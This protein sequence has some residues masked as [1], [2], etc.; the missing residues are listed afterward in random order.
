MPI[1]SALLSCWRRKATWFA[2]V[3][4]LLTAATGWW[5]MP[6]APRCS[7]PVQIVD[8]TVLSPDFHYAAVYYSDLHRGQDDLAA[9]WTIWDLTSGRSQFSFPVS[10]EKAIHWNGSYDLE[11]SPDN[12]LVVEFDDGKARFRKVPSGDHWHSDTATIFADRANVSITSQLA[13]AADGRLFV[14]V[15][16]VANKS[17]IRDLLSGKEV[18]T[19]P[20]WQ[21]VFF[22]GGCLRHN[23][24]REKIEVRELPNGQLRR[25]LECSDL[26][27]EFR[28]RGLQVQPNWALTPDCNTAVQVSD[29]K[30]LVWDGSDGKCRR[31]DVPVERIAQHRVAIS[32]DG[33]YL[34]FLVQRPRDPNHPWLDW[35]LDRLGQLPKEGAELVVYDLTTN[36]EV[37][38]FRDS[39]VPLAWSARDHGFAKFS[40]DGKSLAIVQGES[41]DIY[42]FPLHQPWGRIAGYALMAAAM[43]WVLAWL[44]GR[45]TAQR[46]RPIAAINSTEMA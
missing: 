44:L 38:S 39:P 10:Q 7:V 14:L 12:E 20:P 5:L 24:E 27:L 42:D 22:P 40:L 36:A 33:K 32:P 13:K 28:K 26:E 37:A 19:L 3:V 2:F 34:V 29:G 9:K 17:S 11:F 4:G 45:K 18:G 31:L 41:L 30:I 43:A 21:D 35:L 1:L 23:A 6:H 8:Y 46:R 15:L 16:D 25:D